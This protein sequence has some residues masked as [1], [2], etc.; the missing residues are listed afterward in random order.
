MGPDKVVFLKSCIGTEDSRLVKRLFHEG[1]TFDEQ[2]SLSALHSVLETSVRQSVLSQ[3]D[4]Q[5]LL[6]AVHVLRSSSRE[7]INFLRAVKLVVAEEIRKGTG[8][9]SMNYVVRNCLQVGESLES[10]PAKL[11]KIAASVFARTIDLAPWLIE[12][13]LKELEKEAVG[14]LFF[15]RAI[16]KRT[17]QGKLSKLD[18]VLRGRILKLL[19]VAA[20]KGG[21]D[22]GVRLAGEAPYLLSTFGSDELE[23]NF[24]PQVSRS[25]LR[26]K[27]TALGSLPYLLQGLSADLSSFAEKPLVPGLTSAMKTAKPPANEVAVPLAEQ[28]T[29]RCG[30]A[31]A[32]RLIADA[33][34]TIISQKSSSAVE[35]TAAASV[36]ER[37]FET[38]YGSEDRSSFAEFAESTVDCLVK[39]L[40]GKDS[41]EEARSSGVKSL[42]LV[43][44]ISGDLVPETTSILK[45]ILQR[46]HS[47][48]EL[49][50][51]L[52][53]LAGLTGS[54]LAK[55]KALEEELVALINSKKVTRAEA[56]NTLIVLLTMADNSADAETAE[57]KSAIKATMDANQG[58]VYHNF[59]ASVV[60]DLSEKDLL[61]I[62]KLSEDLI[63]RNEKGMQVPSRTIRRACDV[64]TS[65]CISPKKAVRSASTTSCLK[66]ASSGDTSGL[67]LES[68]FLFEIA[69]SDG[70]SSL[71]GVEGEG[72]VAE[73]LGRAAVS[74]AGGPHAGSVP[75]F[76][77]AAHHPKI[78]RDGVRRFWN[79]KHLPP[80]SEWLRPSLDRILS[81]EG[82]CSSDRSV[83]IGSSAA[84]ESIAAANKDGVCSISLPY[85]VNMLHADAISKLGKDA[86]DLFVT[87]REKGDDRSSETK[88]EETTTSQG[89]ETRKKNRKTQDSARDK[90]AIQAERDRKRAQEEAERLGREEREKNDAL[91]AHAASLFNDAKAGLEGVCALCRAA[92]DSI[93][94]DTISSVLQA[95]IQVASTGVEEDLCRRAFTLLG[96]TCEPRLAAH[97]MMTSA[98]LYE[99][100]LGGG[101]SLVASLFASISAL[102]P[103]LLDAKSFSMLLPLVKSVLTDP[104]HAE[105]SSVDSALKLLEQHVTLESVNTAAACANQ[106]AGSWL[107]EVLEQEDSLFSRAAEALSNLA[108]SALAVDDKLEQVL[109]GLISGKTSVR[110]ATLESLDRLPDL[111]EGESPANLL[112]GRL[113]WLAKCDVDE[114]LIEIAD[115][116]WHRYGHPLVLSEDL[117]ALVDLIGSQHADM[118]VMASIAIAKLLIGQER[119]AERNQAIAKLFKMYLDNLPKR[120]E[121]DT[122]RVVRRQRQSKDTL[123]DNN[124]ATREGVA[125]ALSQLA[126]KGALA[127][128]DIVLVFTFLAARGLGD[129]H[130]EVRGKMASTAVAVVDA[131]GPNAPE[132]LL[133]MIESQLQRVPGKEEKE[134]V[135]VHFDRTHENLVV[136]LGTVATYLPE[137]QGEKRVEIAL[138]LTNTAINSKSESVQRACS[139]C[140]SALS[141]S[142]GARED[143]HKNHVCEKL[144]G[145]GDLATR[146]GAAYAL[147]GFLAGLGLKAMKRMEVILEIKAAL[148]GKK[149]AYKKQSALFLIETLALA[150][151]RV[152]EPYFVSLLPLLLSSMSDTADVRQASWGAAKALMGS[153]SAHG[154]RLVLPTLMDGLKSQ[155]WRTKAGS[156]DLLGAMAFCAPRQL[157]K[158]LPVIVPKLAGTL[159]DAHPKVVEASEAAV[160][161][162]AAV[163]NNPEVRSLCPFLLSALRDPAGKTAGAI[164]AMLQTEFVHSIDAASMALLVP[165]LHRGLRDRST[166]VKKKSA[167]I[168]GSM[169]THASDPSDVLP[170]LDLLVP[171]LRSVLLDPIPEV[172][173]TS[174]SALG[175]LTAGIGIDYL[176]GLLD[177]LEESLV[178]YTLTTAERSGAALGL[179]AVASS[180]SDVRVN[181]VLETTISASSKKKS[182]TE[183]TAAREGAL[184]VLAAMP[185][186]MK[187][188]FEMRLSLALP[189]V[190]K[191]L[192]DEAD[193]VR[194]AALSAGRSIVAEFGKTSLDQLLPLI[195]D[196]I[197]D[198]FWRIRQS[199]TQ[200]LGDLLLGLA[201][202]KASV[203]GSAMVVEE[204]EDENEE[205]SDKSENDGE[206]SE[207]DDDFGVTVSISPAEV[208][209]AVTNALGVE[210]RNEVV[211]TLY[212]ARNDVS[213]RVRLTAIQVWKM[214]I[215]NTPRVLR[216]ILPVATKMIISALSSPDEEQTTTAARALGDLGQ[217]L[218]DRVF[219][220]VLPLLREGLRSE[221]DR[222]RLGACEGLSELIQTATKL[223][224]IEHASELL[225]GIEE[226]LSDSSESVRSASAKI[227]SYL[228]R[229]L[230][231]TASEGVVQNLIVRAA[232]YQEPSGDE[233]MRDENYAL[234][235]LQKVLAFSSGKVLSS[236]VTNVI[237]EIPITDT[238]LMSLAAAARVAE[239]TFEAHLKEVMLAMSQ[240]FVHLRHS[241]P[242]LLDAA[243][244]SVFSSVAASGETLTK[245]LLIEI[246]SPMSHDVEMRVAGAKMLGL[247]VKALGEDAG[248]Y[249]G[250]ILEAAVRQLGD[251]DSGAVVEAWRTLDILSKV[252]PTSRLRNEVV[253]LRQSLRQ[254][255]ANS[256]Y[257]ATD[258]LPGDRIEGLCIKQGPS[259]F[260]P[261]LN[262]G[263]L[264]GSPEL[265]E[266]SALCVAE[267][268]ELSEQKA[269]S[270]FVIK[271]T[272]PL[273]RVI[274]DR[275][276]WQVKAAILHAML[277]L[278]ERCSITLKMLVPQLQSI[279][280]KNLQDPTRTVR[281]RA[282]LALGELMKIHPRPEPVFNELVST[283]MKAEVDVGSRTSALEALSLVSMN[284]K[285]L[286]NSAVTTVPAAMLLCVED[287]EEEVRSAAGTTLGKFCKR[288]AE[289]EDIAEVLNRA[290][291]AEGRSSTQIGGRLFCSSSVLREC[292]TVDGLTAKIGEHLEKSVFLGLVDESFSSREAS[293]REKTAI[294][295]AELYCLFGEPSL[296]ES[297]SNTILSDPG[298]DVRLA[299]LKGAGRCGSAPSDAVPQLVAAVCAA[300]HQKNTM[301]KYMAD[302]AIRGLFLDETGGERS[303]AYK[304]A[305]S[306]LAPDKYEWLGERISK[307]QSTPESDGEYE[308]G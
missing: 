68:L 300:A 79:L 113:L 27:Q 39:W 22:V 174:A 199:S 286:P 164:D 34:C 186:M 91:I 112:L 191:G 296:L 228:S 210:R 131:A 52:S 67:L 129:V 198:T 145:D 51:L 229:P 120:E 77:L 81:D 187:D 139:K 142:F 110:E 220:Q 29:K 285:S 41:N 274:S 230:G 6:T 53:S 20:M 243:V 217:K 105:P 98:C 168:V 222:M 264:N 275:G 238:G 253:Q 4:E 265:R 90:Q 203:D 140:I 119:T 159:T 283:C 54:E 189:V 169:C 269:L 279:F 97:A 76:V 70:F 14:L 78:L 194:D 249:A 288:I 58:P 31:S 227:F 116:L 101:A 281:K 19:T 208:M 197:Q 190:L 182:P 271:L 219:P 28:L 302:K 212:M 122:N 135:L 104:G 179:A 75:L 61:S 185:S 209:A 55:H 1:L 235:G 268:V 123:A 148:T 103:P 294:A 23:Q 172:R 299:A 8:A 141:R 204:S 214:V 171:D 276:P 46:K 213:S 183:V 109:K 25:L 126:K 245:A 255:G 236:V 85:L 184:L 152:F 292:S 287:V 237:A 146:R 138:L 49:N 11:R 151:E 232:E 84:L 258:K 47:D 225:P 30:T 297:L 240:T 73:R 177:W 162:I 17:R 111:E 38:L 241:S 86:I 24:F 293:V 35:R 201:G 246:L 221:N 153:L 216:E 251:V 289:P 118:R 196:G 62:L 260:V 80:E 45:S 173:K 247:F 252:V 36:L 156:A 155:N 301:I 9:S 242:E 125:L 117:P 132:T 282:Q 272:G 3:K 64:V 15:I 21:H 207:E 48:V 121:M 108:E 280:L 176:P 5:D 102:V 69:G 124:Y 94:D 12:E 206:E 223:Q 99:L 298:V 96:S 263:L 239:S 59:S 248:N 157:A 261:I 244:I 254:A 57:V 161:R 295:A 165:P 277:R 273:I 178:R 284:T 181:N 106:Y 95:I 74:C 192:A 133:P 202:A 307:L 147:A 144:Y 114:S 63:S 150:F 128:K 33:A 257:R 107:L 18:S 92:P 303:G 2:K 163:T 93:G 290:L 100:S 226:A 278:L 259:P 256:T 26:E 154:V 166:E 60:K 37:F 233:D 89:A 195:C 308:A 7:R 250:T 32:R 130:D 65:F 158:S 291:H 44:A 82:L 16:E 304:A 170:Y 211:A 205:G 143:E 180:L 188:R 160:S 305:E 40:G 231:H 42:V 200:L 193:S 127:G 50:S 115:L 134:E 87:V 266:Q 267:L 83:A 10:S 167:A 234:D 270:P 149:P 262:E 218:G 66:L 215:F 56:S 71:D 72:L 224:L 306:V 88:V 13:C 136:C 175:S 43:T 137:E